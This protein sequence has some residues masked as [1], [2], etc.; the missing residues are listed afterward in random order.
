MNA[1]VDGLRHLT[2]GQM[3]QF[4]EA[5]INPVLYYASN[6]NN[7]GQIASSVETKTFGIQIQLTSN[8]LGR[9]IACVNTGRL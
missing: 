7:P 8:D 3:Q 9:L 6:D 4:Y 1:T 5:Y 2:Q